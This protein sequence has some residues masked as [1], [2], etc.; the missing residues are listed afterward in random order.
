MK[1]GNSKYALLAL[2]IIAFAESSFFPIPPDI[3]LI[4]MAVAAPNKAFKYAGFTSLFSVI[5]GVAGFFIG[6]GLMEA[7]GWPIINFY[8]LK[9]L[10]EG[11]FA[12]FIQFN[13]WAVFIAALTPIP[14]KVFTIAAGAAATSA[15][16][17]TPF[18]EYFATFMAASILGRSLRFFALSTLIYFFGEKIKNWIDKYFNWACAGLVVLLFGGFAVIKYVF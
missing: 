10:F 7:I 15:A 16:M 14:Y 18:G 2:I 13:F 17:T 5:G 4:A 6:Y 9:P 11:L 1:W 8:H 3:L 12:K